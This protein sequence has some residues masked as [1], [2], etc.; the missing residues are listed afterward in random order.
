M[1]ITWL[2]PSTSQPTIC[3]GP[4][5]YAAP[6]PTIEQPTTT[7]TNNEWIKMHGDE[8]RGGKWLALKDGQLLG[9]SEYLAPLIARVGRKGVLFT[10]VF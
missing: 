4:H 8:H 1:P 6:Y 9:K 3:Y 10:K 5:D 2:Y 7:L